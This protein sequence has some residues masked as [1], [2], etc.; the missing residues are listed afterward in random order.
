MKK[1]ILLILLCLLSATIFC[2][3]AC[4]AGGGNGDGDNE[5][6]QDFSGIVF[7]DL[8]L[9]Y[10]GQEHTIVATG[11]PSQATVEYSNN[12]PYVNAG[13]YAISISVS[14]EGYNTYTKSAT[15]KINKI[16]FPS[17]IVFEDKTAIATG[18]E[19]SILVSG[20]LPQGTQVNYVNNKGTQAGIYEAS[21]TLINPNY[22]T[23][24]LYANLEIYSVAGIAKQTLD[25]IMDRPDP[26]E[27]MPQAFAKENIATNGNVELDYANFVNV[28]N[29]NRKYMGK[30][31]YV[32][33]E[34]V[35]GMDSI[36][37]KFDVVYAVGETIATVYQSFINNNP[38]DY[39]EWTDEVAG[40]KVKIVLDG[41]QSTMLIGNS[42][43]S[44][45]LYADSR[46]N[47]NKGRIEISNGAK[48]TY[49]MQDNYLKFNVALTIQG[50]LV[51]KQVE[52]VRN[53]GV[54]AG[55]LYEYTGLESVALKTSAVIKFNDT[56]TIVMSTKRESDDL[57]VVAYEE[58]YSS[59]TGQFLGARVI[60]SIKT[61]EYDTYWLNIFDVSGIA[62]VKAV[63]N[64]NLISLPNKNKH[65]VYI[66]GSSDKFEPEYNKKL[67]VK[68]SRHFDIEMKDIYYVQAITNGE[69]TE[70][71]IVS[72][73]VPMMFVQSENVN[74]F[75]NEAYENNENA[76]SYSPTLPSTNINV[77]NNNFDSLKTLLDVVKETLTYSELVNQLGTKNS[78]FNE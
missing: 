7:N 52:F 37:S 51:M 40:F 69:Q 31:M 29:I 49:E 34:G 2:F 75:S 44:I 35:E 17:S 45:E 67:M 1:K 25:K 54:V 27:F 70:Y 24:T 59:T 16:D 5:E 46:T 53:D 21:A 15:L 63:E 50:V 56:Y 77:T 38:S 23:K 30:Q 66:N 78:F 10:D 22:N 18:S 68:T 42:A 9:D 4:S 33:W 74:D 47:I 20:Q 28:N 64:E 41:D 19:I 57:L 58:V 8:T 73:Q 13:E 32:L 36:L 62:N 26:W 39:A 14:A 60:E 43:F 76:F 55:Y 71:Q 61:D 65:D 11:V 3:T 48:L 12:G 6:K 72:T